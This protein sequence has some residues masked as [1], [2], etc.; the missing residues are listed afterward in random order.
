VT[1]AN[2]AQKTYMDS[3]EAIKAADKIKA[4]NAPVSAYGGDYPAPAN[5]DERTEEWKRIEAE[6]VRREEEA[7][8][9]YDVADQDVTKKEEAYMV[10]ALQAEIEKMDAEK[11]AEEDSIEIDG[12]V[13]GKAR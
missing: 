1:A 4:E 8:D 9:A 7:M 3:L 6:L 12:V 2:H 5:I 11:E 10:L 13:Y